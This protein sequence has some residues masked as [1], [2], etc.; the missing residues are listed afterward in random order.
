M[1]RKDALLRLRERLIAKRE[2]L[3]KK[4]TDDLIQALPAHG[5]GDVGDAANDG[6]Q[7]EI[8]SQ[9][10]ALES[11]ELVQVERAIQLMREG[12]YGVCELCE[13]SIPI[14]RLK[15]LPFAPLCVAC[16]RAQ[17][18]RRINGEEEDTDANW[19]SA[20]EHEGRMSEKEFSLG[21]FDLAE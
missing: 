7:N 8:N 19:E 14:T 10:A 20:F 3:R 9:L 11:R 15:A 2:S 4:L 12:R 6:A 1:S 5:G 13:D 16:Q 21:D 18:A 17:E